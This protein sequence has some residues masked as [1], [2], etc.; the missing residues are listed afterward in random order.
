MAMNEPFTPTVGGVLALAVWLL[1][2]TALTLAQWFHRDTDQTGNT[3]QTRKRAAKAPQRPA[4]ARKPPPGT[5]SDPHAREE[6]HT[7]ALKG[8][9]PLPVR[10]RPPPPPPPRQWLDEHQPTT[11]M[12]A[13]QPETNPEPATEQ[14]RP[15][16]KASGRYVEGPGG[17]WSYQ[18]PEE[19]KP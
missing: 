7:E 9:G 11:D 4:S 18:R 3:A 12:R 19:T 16:R 5:P 13:V 2:L 17:S 6:D 10:D 1:A 14:I 8:S 15:S